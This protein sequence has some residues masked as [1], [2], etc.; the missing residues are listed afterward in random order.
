MGSAAHGRR[1]DLKNWL[2]DVEACALPLWVVTG[3]PVEILKA[4]E[5]IQD[6]DE[7]EVGV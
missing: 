2:D 3:D 4:G 1:D 5:D 7:G 6:L